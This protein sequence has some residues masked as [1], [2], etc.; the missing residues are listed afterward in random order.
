MLI[1]IV[2]FNP[3]RCSFTFVQLRSN[4]FLT[5]KYEEWSECF[6]LAIP[7]NVY[8]E[9]SRVNT[10]KYKNR[11]FENIEISHCDINDIK[12]KKFKFREK[13]F[14]LTTL[15]LLLLNSHL[16]G[17]Q[18]LLPI[19]QKLLHLLLHTLE[20]PA[21]VRFA[22][23]GRLVIQKLALARRWSFSVK[24]ANVA[25]KQLFWKLTSV[26]IMHLYDDWESVCDLTYKNYDFL[27]YNG[28][29]FPM[30]WLFNI[31]FS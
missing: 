26:H 24:S 29:C 5:R 19:L 22:P 17:G 2:K 31:S 10:T 7:P 23:K 27:N 8:S 11:K 16:T 1:N 21:L 3:K 30:L 9:K 25:F 28:N 13:H 12:H 4:Y 18:K 15:L 6:K 14:S 20:V